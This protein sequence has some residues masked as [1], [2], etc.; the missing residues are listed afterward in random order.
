MGVQPVDRRTLPVNVTAQ[1]WRRSGADRVV[2]T[3]RSAADAGGTTNRVEK[4]RALNVAALVRPGIDQQQGDDARHVGDLPRFAR[5]LETHLR[6]SAHGDADRDGC[7]GARLLTDG[8][9][10]LTIPP[11]NYSTAG[12][13]VDWKADKRRRRRSHCGREVSV[14]SA[15]DAVERPHGDA[16]RAS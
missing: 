8:S 5:R 16:R 13:D 11:F 10:S 7:N 9:Y 6:R 3:R 12:R 4:I 15:G 1:A 14:D 2:V